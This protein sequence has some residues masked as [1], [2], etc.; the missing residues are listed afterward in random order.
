MPNIWSNDEHTKHHK[1]LIFTSAHFSRRPERPNEPKRYKIDS[2]R[3]LKCN[4]CQIIQMSFAYFVAS[5]GQWSPAG[6]DA[7]P[8]VLVLGLLKKPVFV[9][10]S[11]GDL[12]LLRRLNHVR[13]ANWSNLLSLSNLINVP[14]VFVFFPVSIHCTRLLFNFLRGTYSC[15]LFNTWLKH[16]LYSCSHNM[17]SSS[18]LPW[19]KR[20][21]PPPFFFSLL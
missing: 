20:T 9:I 8:L 12:F 1:H 3:F 18:F 19:L 10:K 2:P 21:P 15:I 6:L 7:G 5:E 17:S 16:V 14:A 11:T 4:W 13:W